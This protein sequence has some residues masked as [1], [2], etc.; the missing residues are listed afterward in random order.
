MLLTSKR[1]GARTTI[2]DAWCK[3]SLLQSDSFIKFGIV[4][5][6]GL[7]VNILFFSLFLALGM[8]KYY[9]SP[10]A[11]ELSIIWNFVLN[12][13]WTFRSRGNGSG[14]STKGARFHVVSVI[15]L[16]LSYSTFL[17]LCKLLP[18]F[19]PVIHQI[20]SVMPASLVN[21]LLNSCWTFRPAGGGQT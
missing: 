16:C 4:G 11:V 12:N 17:A 13:N 19:S 3:D 14:I 8:N 1:N 20:V 5:A 21:Y 15:A 9:A 7:A 6:T 10:L 18:E 2:I